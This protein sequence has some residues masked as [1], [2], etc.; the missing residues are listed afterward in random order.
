MRCSSRSC[1][2]SEDSGA[3]DDDIR[4][5]A[6]A[7]GANLGGGFQ[8]RRSNAN[9]FLAVLPDST[10]VV[11]RGGHDMEHRHDA[12]GRNGAE[13]EPFLKSDGGHRGKIGRTTGRVEFR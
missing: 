5:R 13:H 11:H 8:V 3:D 10:L 4:V 7:G 6:L 2:P 12:A 9:A 1:S